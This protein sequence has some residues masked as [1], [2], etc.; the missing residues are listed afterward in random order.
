MEIQ[1][2][3]SPDVSGPGAAD[4][5]ASPSTDD[6]AQT[7]LR[8]SVLGVDN[9]PRPAGKNNKDSNELL[10]LFSLMKKAQ[11]M[12][13]GYAIKEVKRYAADGLMPP[14]SSPLKDMKNTSETIISSVSGKIKQEDMR[15]FQESARSFGEA[16][17]FLQ[18][19][20]DLDP[21]EPDESFGRA[22]QFS[23]EFMDQ[24]P[25]EPDESF[26]RA[27]QFPREF[28]DL[29]P[30]AP[31]PEPPP[32]ASSGGDDSGVAQGDQNLAPPPEPDPEPP[33]FAGD[34]GPP[35]EPGSSDDT[36]TQDPTGSG[37]GSG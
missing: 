15:S 19:F 36:D 3:T 17:E 10:A 27:S 1:P 30:P 11:G 8:G 7:Q 25:P 2:P 21:P 37:T 18:E 13:L 20:V 12:E 35:S 9:R 16:P 24:D 23:R 4:V 6:K 34:P 29:A 22:S 33:P 26:G 32:P 28:M 5:P 31:D 14:G